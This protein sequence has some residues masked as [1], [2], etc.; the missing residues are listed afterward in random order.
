MI[1]SPPPSPLMT[2]LPIGPPTSRSLP[3]V[4]TRVLAAAVAG[5][6]AAT[7][8]ANIA[9]RRSV[10]AGVMTRKRTRPPLGAPVLRRT[11]RYPAGAVELSAL[12]IVG[13]ALG[14]A[15]LI[16]AAWRRR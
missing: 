7:E 16:F 5:A 12:R 2:W 10:S 3:G 13:L 8:H 6:S 11:R 15:V 9:A 4:P 1:V 14:A